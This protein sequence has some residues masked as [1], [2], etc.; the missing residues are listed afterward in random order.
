MAAHILTNQSQTL[1]A[2]PTARRSIRVIM[3][4]I[5][6]DAA[7]IAGK[8][9]SPLERNKPTGGMRPNS[10]RAR[11]KLRSARCRF[12]DG[13]EQSIVVDRLPQIGAGAERTH[14]LGRAG[15][16]M[17]GDDDDW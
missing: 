13:G 6:G 7:W 15:F 2:A 12:R 3:H 11:L 1:R 17:S 4:A 8:G 10:G 16:V 14:A 9:S 5:A